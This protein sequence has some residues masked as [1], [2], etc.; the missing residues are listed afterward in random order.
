MRYVKN[1]IWCQKIRL[2]G[3]TVEQLTCNEQ[4]VGSNPTGGSK[5]YRGVEQR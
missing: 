3:S 2:L 5:M 4:V 1:L